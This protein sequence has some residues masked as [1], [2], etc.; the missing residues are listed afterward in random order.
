MRNNNKCMRNIA[1]MDLVFVV[2]NHICVEVRNKN[3]QRSVE[4]FKLGA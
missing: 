3:T 2:F 1:R 4:L